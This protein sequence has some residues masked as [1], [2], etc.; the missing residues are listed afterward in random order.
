MK[1]F[2]CTAGRE[3]AA[4]NEEHR[5]AHCSRNMKPSFSCSG[6]TPALTL[7]T[8]DKWRQW[9]L[10]LCVILGGVSVHSTRTHSLG[11]WHLNWKCPQR[12]DKNCGAL[13]WITVL[14]RSFYHEFKPWSAALW[15][16]S[17]H[18]KEVPQGSRAQLFWS[19]MHAKICWAQPQIFIGCNSAA[20]IYFFFF[21]FFKTTKLS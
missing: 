20:E 10:G 17:S 13:G 11:T 12:P 21:F 14:D 7:R 16:H 6:S 8:K 9:K 5:A 4:V 1:P 18:F 19:N 3:H 15:D 2:A